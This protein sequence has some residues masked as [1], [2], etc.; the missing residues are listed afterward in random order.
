MKPHKP[1]FLFL[2]AVA[3]NLAYIELFIYAS[4]DLDISA[5]EVGLISSSFR[6]LR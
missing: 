5:K 2:A 1:T 6:S 3:G 4:G